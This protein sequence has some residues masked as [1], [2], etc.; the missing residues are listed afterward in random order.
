MPPQVLVMEAALYGVNGEQVG[1][2]EL[3]LGVGRWEQVGPLHWRGWPN[4]SVAVG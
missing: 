1:S 3:K 2:S 4:A